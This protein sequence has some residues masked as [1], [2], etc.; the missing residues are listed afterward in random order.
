MDIVA[1]ENSIISRLKTKVIPRVYDTEVDTSATPS[2][3]YMVV[4]FSFPTRTGRDRHLTNVRNDTR[5]G[6][7]TIRVIST[8]AASAKA[9]MNKAD[10]YLTGWEP[11]NSGALVP[12][13]NTQF[14]T[15]GT[16]TQPALYYR[17]MGYTFRTNLKWVTEPNAW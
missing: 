2:Y 16:T 12:D 14:S 1:V 17:T 11:T 6:V 7:V 5:V 8:D 10:D 15:P 13:F 3:P 9:I 4:N